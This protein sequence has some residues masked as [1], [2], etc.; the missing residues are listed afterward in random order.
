MV[1]RG[2][3]LVSGGTDN[4]LLLVDLKPA[5]IDGARVEV[6]P[7]SISPASSGASD[8]LLIAPCSDG[9]RPPRPSSTS[10]G[11]P[12]A[13]LERANVALNGLDAAAKTVGESIVTEFLRDGGLGAR[14]L[15]LSEDARREVMSSL[16]K[17]LEGNWPPTLF[18]AA[19]AELD[20]LLRKQYMPHFFSHSIFTHV[21]GLLGSYDAEALF[22]PENLE[23]AKRELIIAMEGDTLDT[24]ASRAA[25]HDHMSA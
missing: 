10:R 25:A 2:Y 13:V 12:Q 6:R 21:L 20:H 22:P 23:T 8:G 17:S 11:P 19:E 9:P 18:H 1:A 5:G 24:H 4:H 7:R 16:P 3:S 14:P 15:Q